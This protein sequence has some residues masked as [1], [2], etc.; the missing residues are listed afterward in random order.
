LS[1]STSTSPATTPWFEACAG[2]LDRALDL[3][4]EFFD[5]LFDAVQ[6]AWLS[7]MLR[8]MEARQSLAR[9]MDDAALHHRPG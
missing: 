1:S 5:P 9:G 2:A 6:N 3:R 8:R 7:G 4:T